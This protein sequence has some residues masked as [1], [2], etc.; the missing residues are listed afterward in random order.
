ML[1]FQFRPLVLL[2]LLLL[3]FLLLHLFG[4]LAHF[5]AVLLEA[6]ANRSKRNSSPASALRA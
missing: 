5:L 2:F 6:L 1:H 4:L 3:R